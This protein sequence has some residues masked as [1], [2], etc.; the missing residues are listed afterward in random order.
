MDGYFRCLCKKDKIYFLTFGGIIVFNQ[1]FKFSDFYIFEDVANSIIKKIK[2]EYENGTYFI[3][4]NHG[5]QI[6]IDNNENII[7]RDI[8]G[9]K[10]YSYS[11]KKEKFFGGKIYSLSNKYNINADNNEYPLLLE[12]EKGE[13]FIALF[14]DPNSK[15][16]YIFNT[17]EIY[18]LKG[19][20]L[21]EI[22]MKDREFYPTAA[23]LKNYIY[24]LTISSNDSNSY[25]QSL[26]IDIND[27]K[28]LF[29]INNEKNNAYYRFSD[30]KVRKLFNNEYI[31]IKTYNKLKIFKEF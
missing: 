5:N 20:K 25:L 16:D 31:Y 21:F 12:D 11:G 1:N 2:N 28:T 26:K 4:Y 29:N 14:K 7:V 23:L 22:K 15:N 9:V 18:N 24:L 27:H 13:I 3:P 19:N 8:S 17:V 10:I 6:I 30:I